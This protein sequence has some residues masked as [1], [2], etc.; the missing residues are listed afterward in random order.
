M[1]EEF[2]YLNFFI[3]FFGF[4]ATMIPI[5]LV[6]SIYLVQAKKPPNQNER[7]IEKET[8]KEVVMIPCRYCG[9]LYPQTAL[10]CSTCGAGERLRKESKNRISIVRVLELASLTSFVGQSSRSRYFEIATNY[11]HALFLRKSSAKNHNSC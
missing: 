11:V 8:I 10:F 4:C 2:S 5:V 3:I 9:W 7:V 1:F 6:A